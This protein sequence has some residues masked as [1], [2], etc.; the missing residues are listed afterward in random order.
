M[1]KTKITAM[2]L[3][4]AM[5]TTVLSGCGKKGEE[6]TSV[7]DFTD[8]DEKLT[9][10]WLGYPRN[11][12]AE[13]GSVP[14]TTLEK[15]FNVELEPLFYEENKYNDKK[16]MLMSGGEIPDLIYELDPINVQQDVDQ[17]FI[18]DVPYEVIKS[19]SILARCMKVFRTSG[20]TIRST[21]RWRYLSS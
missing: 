10:K 12:G 6:S 8:T 11:P 1:K 20:F 15:T 16:T 19:A 17:D 7:K 3:V 21:L 4:T 14:E 18:V 2:C 5:V 13:E 9:I